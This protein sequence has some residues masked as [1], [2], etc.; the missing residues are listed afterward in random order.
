M[1]GCRVLR[2]FLPIWI[3]MQGA[4]HL[5]GQTPPPAKTATPKAVPGKTPKVAAPVSAKRDFLTNND[6]IRMLAAGLDEETVVG[7]IQASKATFVLDADNLIRLKQAKVPPGVLRAMLNKNAASVEP[8][9]ATSAEPP[10]KTAVKDTGTTKPA[11][12]AELVAAIAAVP[13]HVTVRQGSTVAQLAD[14][15]QKILFI[16]SEAIDAKTAIANILLSDVGLQLLTMGMSSQMMMWNPYLGDSIAKAANL[17]KGMLLNRGSDTRGFEIETLP[18]VTAS[19]TLKEARTELFVPITR[20]LASANLDPATLEPVLLKLDSRDTDQSRVLSGRKVLIKQEKK[21]RFD[22]KPTNER[23]ESNVEQD[24]V[25]VTVERLPDNVFKITT[26]ENLKR[27]EYALVF[28]K[29]DAGGAY[30]SN[31]A[32]KPETKPDGGADGAAP[33]G[34]ANIPSG[35]SPEMMAMMTPEQIRMMQQQ[36]ANPAQQRGGMFGRMKL[37]PQAPPAPAVPT[38]GSMIGF[39]AWDFRVIP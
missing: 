16:K 36:Q 23:Q 30:T 9:T 18:G 24:V 1:K 22:M 12:H 7:A 15:P 26:R 3:A 6:V 37:G 25:P 39:I 38:D 31:V 4:V 2:A 10:V 19:V 32:L 21:G 11:P 5:N 8:A 29:K 27:G 13:D 35:M 14:R 28:R 17:G 34:D 20:Y 33:S